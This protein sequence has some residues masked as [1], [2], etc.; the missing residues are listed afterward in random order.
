MNSLYIKSIRWMFVHLACLT[1]VFTPVAMGQEAKRVSKAK[2]QTAIDMLGLNRQMTVGEFYQKN[3]YLFPPRIQ[4]QIEPMMTAFKNQMM[5]TF[6]VLSSKT[7]S[8]EEIATIRA[9]QGSELLNVQWFGESER[10]FKFQN[11]NI[12][13]IDV[14]NF[15]DMFTRIIASDEKYRKQIEPKSSKKISKTATRP[16]YPDVTKAEWKTMSAYNKVSYV[17]NLRLLLQDARNV[18]RAKE[19]LGKNSKKN[20][21][22]SE[23]FLEKNKHFFALFFG[24]DVEAAA[25]RSCIVAGYVSE[26]RG[27]S[28][29]V[30]G[31]D[32]SYEGKENTMYIK[33]RNICAQKKQM[34]CNPYVF[35]TPGGSPT[36]VTPQLNDSSFQTATHWDGPCDSNSRLSNSQ[37]NIP[38]NKKITSGRYE[39]GNLL[40]DDER[41]KLFSSEQGKD[42]YRLTEDYLLGILKFQGKVGSDVK[43]LVIDDEI[44]E[45]IKKDKIHFDAQISAANASCKQESEATSKNSKIVHEKNYWQACD[46]L[47][48]RY[49]FIDELLAAKCGTNTFNPKTLKCTCSQLDDSKMPGSPH[50]PTPTDELVSPS[51]PG[52]VTPANPGNVTP[53]NPG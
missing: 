11:T 24:Q 43:K 35:G 29:S 21:K 19:A 22:T 3:K 6:E 45:Q 28:C 26:Y 46:Q 30:K 44:L 23:Y 2:M 5:P 8:G 51:T 12:S 42:N 39:D 50:N 4:K 1:M 20:K 9:S 36:C 14:I 7:T 34:A 52:N 41:R 17:V 33:A 15:D 53:A 32:K 37:S 47:H 25:A 38:T 49:L 48:S 40:P 13:E 27:S 18:L 16:K 31:I 10:M